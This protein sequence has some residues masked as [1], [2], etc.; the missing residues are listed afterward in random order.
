MVPNIGTTDGRILCE[1]TKRNSDRKLYTT[2]IGIGVNFDT[3][4]VQVFIF[5]F[6]LCFYF[7]VF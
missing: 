4:L 3:S 6:V 5:I 1:I 7:V 2:F